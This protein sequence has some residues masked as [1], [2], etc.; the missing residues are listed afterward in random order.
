MSSTLAGRHLSTDE[1]L[2]ALLGDASVRLTAQ[3]LGLARL[4]FQGPHRHVVASELHLECAQEGLSISLATVYN[5]LRH[6][7]QAGLLREVSVHADSSFF[8]TN[9]GPHG[10]AFDETTQTLS[11]VPMPLI[12]LPEGM[13]PAQLESVDVIYRVRSTPA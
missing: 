3:R 9:I 11:D 8:D 1:Q 7:V 6:F 13:D 10:H 4:L 2:R 5:T 12:G